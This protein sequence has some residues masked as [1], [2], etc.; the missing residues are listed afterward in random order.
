MSRDAIFIDS[1]RLG[2]FLNSVGDSVAAKKN[3][4][5]EVF[6]N[7]SGYVLTDDMRVELSKTNNG[8]IFL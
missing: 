4:L 8:R 1:N 7:T 3:L 2:V 6:A 5:T